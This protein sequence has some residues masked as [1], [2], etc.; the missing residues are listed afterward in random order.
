MQ[1]K[2]SP[3]LIKLAAI[4]AAISVQGVALAASPAS[5]P[6]AAPAA[7]TQ[8]SPE[9]SAR[10]HKRFGH[11]HH[12]HQRMMRHGHHG[13]AALLIPGYGPLGEKSVAA[14][15]LTA[16]QKKLVEEAKAA[17]KELR[18]LKFEA[19]KAQ[20]QARAEQLKAGTLD[21]RAA[22]KQADEAMEKARAERGQIA[23][24][25][26][27]VWDA[28]SADQQKK[29]TAY[30]NDRAQKQ[31]ERMEKRAERVKA[32]QQKADAAPAAADKASS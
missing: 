23:D 2:T 5:T 21:P 11:H 18:T 31:A 25:W 15:E 28:L 32:R 19:F 14:L 10:D 27:A 16:D 26:L 20:R 29:V 24:K 22:I 9:T 13:K 30:F 1:H 4:A 8:N 17:Q 12:H 6:D 7:T 3:L